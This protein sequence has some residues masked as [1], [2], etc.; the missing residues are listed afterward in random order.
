MYGNN[1]NNFNFIAQSVNNLL[2]PPM[3]A[4]TI[5]RC[6]DCVTTTAYNLH[7]SVPTNLHSF[8]SQQSLY[9]FHDASTIC[10]SSRRE[11]FSD[12]T[13]TSSQAHSIS[14]THS[15]SLD[16]FNSNCHPK[17]LPRN[18]ISLNNLNEEE[19]GYV[20]PWILPLHCNEYLTILSNCYEGLTHSVSYESLHFEQHIDI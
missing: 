18:C 1:D 11:S 6:S 13:L 10:S 4:Y 19:E 2:L 12:T 7:S 15:M 3:T 8:Y 9:R 16:S 5:P 20:V 14:I 17:K